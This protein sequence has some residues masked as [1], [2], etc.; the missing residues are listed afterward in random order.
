MLSAMGMIA[1]FYNC[2]G[3][4]KNCEEVYVK[5]V[6]LIEEFYERDSVEAGNAYF[7]IGVY[8]FE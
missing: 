7:M 6:S 1:S 2:L 8:Y 4:Q 3:R 5:Y